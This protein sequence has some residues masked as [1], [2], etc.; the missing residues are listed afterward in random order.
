MDFKLGH[1]RQPLLPGGFLRGNP[2][3]DVRLENIQGQ[4]A[5]VEHLIVEGTN[6][7]FVA[8]SLSSRARAT[9]ES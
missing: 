9:P 6:I 2:R 4:C 8:E 1:Y 3:V 5:R 7:E